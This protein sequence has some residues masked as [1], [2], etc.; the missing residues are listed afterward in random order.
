MTHGMSGSWEGRMRARRLRHPHEAGARWSASIR[1]GLGLPCREYEALLGK[2]VNRVV[3]RG[4][5]MRWDFVG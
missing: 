5:P 2:R 4:T 1:P 3:P